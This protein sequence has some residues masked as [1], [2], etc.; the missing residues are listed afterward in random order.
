MHG[1]TLTEADAFSIAYQMTVAAGKNGISF[2]L[3]GHPELLTATLKGISAFI[4][5]PHKK[6]QI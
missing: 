4:R 6:E 2:L 3:K 1:E 5:I